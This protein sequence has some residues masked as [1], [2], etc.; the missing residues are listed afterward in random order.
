MS[1]DQDKM[2]HLSDCG[3]HNGPA[4]SDTNC[5]C[6]GVP[7]SL[8]QQAVTMCQAAGLT[9]NS[10]CYGE[11]LG[12]ALGLLQEQSE[13]EAAIAYRNLE[14][15][16]SAVIVELE[17]QALGFQNAAKVLDDD[18]GAKRQLLSC[19]DM[20]LKRAAAIE[21]PL[22]N[23]VHDGYAN[24]NGT[25]SDR[26][27]QGINL[28][29]PDLPEGATHWEVNGKA[30]PPSNVKDGNYTIYGAE[31]DQHGSVGAWTRQ[32]LDPEE[33]RRATLRTKHEIERDCIIDGDGVWRKRDG[34]SSSPVAGYA[35]KGV[36][37][38]DT[39][40]FIDDVG[41]GRGKANQDCERDFAAPILPYLKAQ[42]LD[43][44]NI[45]AVTYDP[46]SNSV[47]YR[48]S[49][50]IACY[51]VG[52]RCWNRT[53]LNENGFWCDVRESESTRKASRQ[54]ANLS[55]DANGIAQPTPSCTRCGG[56]L[57]PGRTTVC[58]VCEPNKD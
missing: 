18:L 4:Y 2:E 25:F 26:P 13:Q 52:A 54:A 24:R 58:K 36:W 56:S 35:R 38:G 32:T 27:P 19:A 29:L 51:L 30:I 31:K 42:G 57:E 5:S 44:G 17:Q 37:V 48:W 1:D 33:V 22:G 6:G 12:L 11:V 34:A 45:E 3:L 47:S 55:F 23:V 7:L 40:Y 16:K 49:K 21:N 10:P 53:R 46:N 41:V 9:P 14:T 15:C 50:H 20:L 8:W 28:T 39:E 43:A